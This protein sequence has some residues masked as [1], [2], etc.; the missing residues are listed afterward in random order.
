MYLLLSI[1][2]RFR[3]AIHINPNIHHTV[4][5]RLAFNSS[6]WRIHADIVGH[7]Q[8]YFFL[9]ANFAEKSDVMDAVLTL[10]LSLF[11]PFASKQ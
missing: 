2:S 1:K 5:M 4:H 11:F 8:K 6:I 7:N 9:L 3:F 10:M